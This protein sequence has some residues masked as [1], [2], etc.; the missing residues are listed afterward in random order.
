MNRRAFITALGSATAAWP[1]F[2]RAQRAAMPTIGLLSSNAPEPMVPFVTAF[3]EGLAEAGYSEGQNVAIEYRWAE[4]RYERLPA[5]AAE[6]VAR[7]VNVIVASGGTPSARAAKQADS[8]IPVV[9]TAVSDPVAAGLIDSLARPGGHVT[10]FS[11]MG[12]ELVPKRLEMLFELLPHVDTVALLLNP[13]AEIPEAVVSRIEQLAAAKNARLHTLKAA[14][15]ADI[16]AAAARL[17]ELSA[18]GLLV[19]D[20]SFFTSRREQIVALAARYAIP[21]I[22][23]WR[24]F[25]IAGGLVSYGVSL[26][27]LYR[28]SGTR[29]ARILKGAKPADLP[30][31]QPAILELVVNLKTAKALGLEIPASILYRANEVID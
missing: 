1:S 6:L 28:L 24:D 16:D 14:T 25:A 23:Q 3:R 31:E 12:T 8:R 29:T 4:G 10:G 5:L 21:A 15:A 9:F 17:P 2:V 22:Y 20:D 13:N 18:S 27:A 30:V 7:K 26:A 11:I 19:A